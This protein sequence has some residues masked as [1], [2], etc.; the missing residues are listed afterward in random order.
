MWMLVLQLLVILA[1]AIC[2]LVFML[3]KLVGRSRVPMGSKTI[4]V[5]AADTLIGSQIS[6]HLAS[7]GF[8][9]FAGV[10]DSSSKGAQRLKSFGSPWLHVIPLDVTKNDSLHY[11][12]KAVREHFHAGEKGTKIDFVVY[13]FRNVFILILTKW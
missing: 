9:V 3:K 7:M 12:I 10:S 1:V 8:R 6:A 11:A 4:L 5:T 2:L 13:S